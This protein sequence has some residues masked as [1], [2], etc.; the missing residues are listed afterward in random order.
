MHA[1]TVPL[2]AVVLAASLG[3]SVAG[4]LEPPPGPVAPTMKTL[5][6]IEPRTPIASL[7]FTI[8][9]AGSYYLVGDL[10]TAGHGIL[11][12]ASDV[13]IDLM[14][15]TITGP[16]PDSSTGLRLNS[17]D[18]ENLTVRNGTFRSF[19]EGV[20]TRDGF[21]ETLGNGVTVEGVRVLDIGLY[22]IDLRGGGHLVRNCLAVVSATP[23]PFLTDGI[24]VMDGLIESS[25]ARGFGVGLGVLGGT[26]LNSVAIDGDRRARGR[27]QRMR[28]QKQ[29]DPEPPAVG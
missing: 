9:S 23:S 24:V 2:L 27:G 16:G 14:G 3:L 26:I 25:Q 18:H 6:E 12:E 20:V 19:E 21:E 15:F 8:T 1:R 10:S 4:S 13:T 22:G 29:R 28:G 17:A 11:V 7:P 5:L